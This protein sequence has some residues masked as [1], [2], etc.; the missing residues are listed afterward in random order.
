VRASLSATRLVMIVFG[1]LPIA[2]VWLLVALT[3]WPA[4]AAQASAVMSLASGAL[5]TEIALAHWV[6]VP[7]ASAHEPATRTLKSRWPWF[8]VALNVFAYRLADVQARILTSWRA[9]AYYVLAMAAV[10][11]AIRL[12]RS[13][14]LRKQQPAFDAVDE[15]RFETLNLSE[16]L[17]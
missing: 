6:K 13:G 14:A 11:I 7:F 9:V 12:W 10:V 2:C 5:L 8:I 4:G 15:D 16:A 17:N 3:R 1:V